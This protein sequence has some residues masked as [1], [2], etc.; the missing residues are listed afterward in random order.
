MRGSPRRGFD[1]A[2]HG[3]ATRPQATGANIMTPNQIDLVQSSFAKVADIAD[4]AAELFYGRLFEI[5]PEVQP[6]FRGDMRE[7]GRKLMTTLGVVVGGL[8]N[9]DAI[10]SAAKALA[11]KH[12]S[13]GVK[14]A[15]YKPVGEALIWT[16]EK[17]LGEDFSPEVKTAWVSA[18]GVLSGVMIAEAYGKEAAA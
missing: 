1:R 17:G 5:A 16:L 8:K 10:A 12:V 14:A 3:G 4:V 15:D 9:L 6:L 2:V 13:Y 18:Y 11:V 7:Q